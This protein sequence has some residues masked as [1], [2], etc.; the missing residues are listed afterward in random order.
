[1]AV[2]DEHDT[3]AVRRIILQAA[4]AAWEERKWQD[5]YDLLLLS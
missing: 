2:A 1:M 3:D 5:T 4:L